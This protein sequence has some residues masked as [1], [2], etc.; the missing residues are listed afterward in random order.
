MWVL[1][2]KIQFSLKKL[3][4]LQSFCNREVFLHPCDL[5]MRYGGL[6]WCFN[7]GCRKP[8]FF[9]PNRDFIWFSRIFLKNKKFVFDILYKKNCKSLK[10]WLFFFFMTESVFLKNENFQKFLWILKSPTSKLW[11]VD[12]SQNISLPKIWSWQLH[13]VP[14]VAFFSSFRLKKSFDFLNNE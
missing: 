9:N 13:F 6:Y 5:F 1:L 2:Q 4:K 7:K 12:F 14:K 10:F 3:S 11:D 8:F